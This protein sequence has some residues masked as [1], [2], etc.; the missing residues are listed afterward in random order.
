MDSCGGEEQIER[1]EAGLSSKPGAG[2][3]DETQREVFFYVR[4]FDDRAVED[5]EGKVVSVYH[6]PEEFHFIGEEIPQERHGF[7]SG[8]GESLSDR[9]AFDGGPRSEAAQ[10]PPRRT[11][12]ER[13]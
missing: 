2:R 7:A 6:I 1:E 4:Q 3:G 12:R 11:Q 5:V 9:R 10:C 8:H 13:A